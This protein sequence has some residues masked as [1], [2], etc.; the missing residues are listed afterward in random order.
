[1]LKHI[2]SSKYWKAILLL[3]NV[4]VKRRDANTVL[5][6]IWGLIQPFINISVISYFMSFVL[7]YDPKVIVVNLVGALPF[8]TFILQT[9]TSSS[10]SLIS[11][12]EILKR[13]ILPKT[14]FPLADVLSNAYTLLYSFVAMYIALILIFPAFLSWKII[15]I[16]LLSL[17]LIISIMSAGIVSAFLTPYI[18]D[19]PQFITVILGVLYWTIPIIYPYS[20]VPESKRI[21]FEWHP[22]FAVI[23]PM[24]ELVATSEIPSLIIIAKSW[25]VAGIVTVL[26]FLIY[27]K[28]ARN[29][30][31]Y[32]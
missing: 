16:P 18:R 29:I 23:R 31:Y 14:Y 8:W 25:L 6:S 24:Q 15:F 7:R 4:S 11:H 20:I 27:R 30:I 13:V 21:F 2:F 3:V 22:I 26:S 5:G 9:L 12:S 10:N 28:V 17:P 32:L 19:M 1:M